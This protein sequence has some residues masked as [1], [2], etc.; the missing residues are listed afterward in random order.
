[1][2]NNSIPAIAEWREL[3]TP[4]ENPLEEGIVVPA[5]PED[6]QKDNVTA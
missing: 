4:P 2:D 1:M 3:P 6:V 5:P